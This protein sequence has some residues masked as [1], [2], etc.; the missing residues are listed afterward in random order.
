MSD[1]SVA[2][3]GTRPLQ[4]LGIVV[5]RPRQQAD[6]LLHELERLG[7]RAYG[8]P[9]IE[10]VPPESWDVLDGALKSLGEFHWVVFT[11]AN[12]VQP[13]IDRLGDVRRLRQVKIAAIGVATSSA[14]ACHGLKA[15]LVPD[16]FV[17]EGLLE[18]FP[19]VDGLKVLLP[20]AAQARDVFPEGLRA[21][22]VQV[23]VAPVYR[24][25]PNPSA[26]HE[27]RCLFDEGR[28]DIVM[29]TASSTVKYFPCDL[30]ASVR[31]VCIGPV[32]AAAA[33]D[34]G[35]RVDAV[36][37]EHTAAGLTQAILSLKE[38]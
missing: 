17:A 12:A 2:A 22:G 25:V 14:L 37:P 21:R 30:P 20:R 5:T 28:I 13:F 27:L 31:V 32:T 35:F 15:D 9:S 6:G 11:S 4:G 36:P 38:T 26:A 16:D 23:V 7:A 24:T 10:L 19:A 3:Q 18:A 33:R 29:F 34:R 1:D 8:I